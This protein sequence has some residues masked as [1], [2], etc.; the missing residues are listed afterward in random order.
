MKNNLS[1]TT[2]FSLLFVFLL[3]GFSIDTFSQKSKIFSPSEVPVPVLD[4]IGFIIDPEKKIDEE[5]RREIIFTRETYFFN[6]Y[7]EP[8]CV[9][10][11]N[12][13]DP[14]D[15]DAFADKLVELW[16]LEKKTNGRFVFQIHCKSKKKVVFRIGSRLKVFYTKSFLTEL[17]AD[18]EEIHF[19]GDAVGTGDFVSIQ[20]LGDHIFK[21]IRYDTKLSTYQG[22]T[23]I[24]S[25][26]PDRV[27]RS[28][29][30]LK[31]MTSSP[32]APDDPIFVESQGEVQIESEG[33]ALI[34]SGV[35]ASLKNYFSGL[36]QEEI[37]QNFS[38]INTS[39]KITDIKKVPNA[40]EIDNGHI[41]DPHNMLSASAE[42]MINGM[43]TNLEDS[44]GYQVAVVCLNSIGDNDARVWGTD[45]FNLWG[46]GSKETENGLLM[47][48]IHDIH[49]IDF[50]TGRGTE[51]ILTDVDCYNIQQEEMVPHFKNDDYATGMIRGTQAVCDFFYGSPPI[52][53][54]GTTHESYDTGYDDTYYEEEP[55]NF[56]QSDIWAIYVMSA[57]ILTA[58]WLVVFMMCFF[59]KDLH[60]RYF[61]LKFFS[62]AVWPFVFPIPFALLYFLNKSMMERWRNTTR[63]SPTTGE[64][65]HKLDDHAEDK[66]LAKGQLT[67]E[68]VKSI[69]YDVWVS[70]GG[71]EVLVLAYKKWFSKYNACPSCKFKTYWKEYDRTITAA[72]YDS[73]GTGERKY[74]CESCGHSK[75]E[76]YT[77]ARKTRSSSSSSGGSSYSSGGS[78]YSGGGGS[79]YGGGSSRGGGSGSRW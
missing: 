58:A 42:E 6:R 24:H 78:S 11:D 36:S 59:I 30:D 32:Y 45:L 9:R 25:Q 10:I 1:R 64:E 22:N 53:S 55:Y 75:V 46:I 74:K 76:R 44:L 73:T 20:K 29:G 52:Y 72:T 3:S 43:L 8:I 23:G 39:G 56:F 35:D 37:D 54:S 48:L 47:L 41:T 15:L 70:Y 13:K 38:A 71:K 12:I 65:M 17:A 5:W 21:E 68:K 51:G 18:I 62:L 28:N 14:A 26:Y 67:E 31:N 49:G 63:F 27:E 34:E 7:V 69:D 77:I 79:S 40:R 57:G 66:H 19:A 16:D 50:I 33:E 4:S 60:K 61:T 2:L